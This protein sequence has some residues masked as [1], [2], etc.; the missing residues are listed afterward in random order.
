MILDCLSRAEIS[1]YPLSKIMALPNEPASSLDRGVC[2]E[3]SLDTKKA[4]Y[5]LEDNGSDFLSPTSRE[6]MRLQNGI[7][8]KHLIALFMCIFFASTAGQLHVSE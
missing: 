7:A 3:Q 1:T 2:L 6:T 5:K 4:S 8:W